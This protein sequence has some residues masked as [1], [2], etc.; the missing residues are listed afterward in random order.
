MVRV[1]SSE[2][3]FHVSTNAKRAAALTLNALFEEYRRWLPVRSDVIRFLFD[4][5]ARGFVWAR[6]AFQR[7]PTRLSVEQQLMTAQAADQLAQPRGDI[8]PIGGGAGGTRTH[9][10][11]PDRIAHQHVQR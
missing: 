4:R 11:P 3:R 1:E 9:E 8:G 5:P 2:R 10:V 6:H 7:Q